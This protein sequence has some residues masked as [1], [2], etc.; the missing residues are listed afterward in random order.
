MGGRSSRTKGKTGEYEVRD[1]LR[2]LG[3]TAHRVPSS[4]AAQGFKGD[5][6][7]ETPS[8]DTL[9]V[10]VKR[11]HNSFKR[12][13]A[14]TVGGPVFMKYFDM[15]AYLTRNIQDFPEYGLGGDM[16]ATFVQTKALPKVRTM[17]RM[18]KG[19]D[20][21]AVRDDHSPWVFIKYCLVER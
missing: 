11:Y 4:G 7:A 21:L 1:H 18:L 17:Y 15:Y 10:E 9:L 14:S 8:G 20:M 5:V 13:Y 6:R 19:C 2:A 12:L 16:P 3:Y